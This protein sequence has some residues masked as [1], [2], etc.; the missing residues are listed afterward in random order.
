MFKIMEI[1]HAQL[2]ATNVHYGLF[3][4]FNKSLSYLKDFEASIVKSPL[5]TKV[6]ETL[7]LLSLINNSCSRF[8]G[9][10]KYPP[11]FKVN[12][13]PLSSLVHFVSCF[14][15]FG[16]IKRPSSVIEIEESLQSLLDRI[17]YSFP[18]IIGSASNGNGEQF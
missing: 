11:C 9:F 8:F 17:V 13:V 14:D 6:V 16:F 1:T 5:L 12:Q 15:Y 7:A 10:M 18:F 4:K 2:I 3:G